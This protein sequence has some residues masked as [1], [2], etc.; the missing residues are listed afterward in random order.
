MPDVNRIKGTRK[1]ADL[2]FPHQL[3]TSTAYRLRSLK[4]GYDPK[5]ENGSHQRGNQASYQSVTRTYSQQI[6]NPAT[7]KRTHNA[8]NDIHQQSETTATHN[9]PRE[10]SG[11]C[12]NNDKPQPT[13]T[14]YFFKSLL[15]NR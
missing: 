1:D 9:I 13:H 2:L 6:E 4:Q 11:H 14:I 5:Q 7:D 8:N 12:S 10:P 3:Y 15:I